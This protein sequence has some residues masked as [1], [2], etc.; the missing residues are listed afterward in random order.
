[1]KRWRKWPRRSSASLTVVAES[2]FKLV[3][4]HDGAKANFGQILV[5]PTKGRMLIGYKMMLPSPNHGVEITDDGQSKGGKC[6]WQ[7]IQD[8]DQ[9][10]AGD[11]LAR[12]EQGA[13]TALTKQQMHQS[14]HDGAGRAKQQK[15][16]DDSK[17]AHQSLVEH[18][19][20]DCIATAPGHRMA[21][22]KCQ[23][24]GSLGSRV[25]VLTIQV[26]L[27]VARQTAGAQGQYQEKQGIN[28]CPHDP[29]VWLQQVLAASDQNNRWQQNGQNTKAATKQPEPLEKGCDPI[30][31]RIEHVLLGRA[32]QEAGKM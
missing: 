25:L 26:S 11:H 7:Q 23:R 5:V 3:T 19:S 13:V 8:S 21:V 2:V 32:P 10:L 24:L 9:S 12:S 6:R 1:M 20:D 4:A 31:V 27:H 30:Q 15:P 17:P 18:A 22:G 29:L 28:K 16:E 14:K